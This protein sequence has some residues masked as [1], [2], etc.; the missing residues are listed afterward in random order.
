MAYSGTPTQHAFSDN[1]LGNDHFRYAINIPTL[2]T[3][4]KEW[5]NINKSSITANEFSTLLTSLVEG[6]S[7]TEK[8]MAGIL[9]NYARGPLKKID[10]KLFDLWLNHLK[11]WAEV[12][13]L[14]TGKYAESEIP[15]NFNK[16][17]KL[18]VAFAKSK[19]IEKRRAS[20]VLLCSP[21]SKVRDERLVKVAFENINRL[22]F[23]KEVLIT[24]AIS[25]V[26]RSA[27]KHYK[28]EVQHFVS[29]HANSLPKL[30][31]RETAAKLKT[32]RKTNPK[33]SKP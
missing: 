27:V 15:D 32:G 10:V 18:L 28:K 6:K 14:C 24:K 5:M 7:H 20:I 8:T 16:W 30:A 22:K 11:G 17:N 31:L 12:D 25:W 33:R 4:G 13:N 19:M 23:E 26:L 21:L 9:L 1:Y 2:R 3:I 29:L